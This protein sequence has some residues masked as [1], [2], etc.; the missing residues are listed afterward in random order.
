MALA[1]GDPAEADDVW[2]RAITDERYLKP[3]GTLH[4]SAFSGRR[5]LGPPSTPG[6]PWSLELSG[7]LL[8]LIEGLERK[9]T[10]F[11]L[12]R[13]F[14]GVMFQSVE[15]LRSEAS[16]FRTDV[17]F[18]PKPND[19]AHADFVGFGTADKFVIRDW[20]QDMLGAVRPDG[21]AAIDALRRRSAG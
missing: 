4:N 6:R 5:V 13:R 21:L 17:I 19:S 18:T 11:C 2:L 15:K 16:G 10:D 14:A 12:G 8:S 20:L 3:D 9:C 1:D 7:W